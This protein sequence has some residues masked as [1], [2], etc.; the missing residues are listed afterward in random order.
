MP[1]CVERSITRRTKAYYALNAV[2]APSL[3]S[4]PQKRRLSTGE[5]LAIGLEGCYSR[6]VAARQQG[7]GFESLANESGVCYSLKVAREQ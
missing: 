3:P 7:S 1:I 5:G 4:F 2:K 6:E